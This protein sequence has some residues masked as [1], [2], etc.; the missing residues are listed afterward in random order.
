MAPRSDDRFQT[1]EARVKHAWL[2]LYNRELG[3][4]TQ[5]ELAR[6]I[7]DRVGREVQ[8]GQVG[9]WLRGRE[10]EKTD[11]RNALAIELGVDAGW[12]Y[13]APHSKAPAPPELVRPYDSVRKVPASAKKPKEK[14]KGS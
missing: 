2:L 5:A 14:P 6:R 7:S 3:E 1:Y 13:H 10:P 11:D 12:L 4:I 8:Q 9:K